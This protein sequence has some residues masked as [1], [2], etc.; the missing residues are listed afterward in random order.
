MPCFG[1]SLPL[2]QSGYR[3]YISS[4]LR[5][6]FRREES[7]FLDCYW[8]WQS[9]PWQEEPSEERP[10]TQPEEVPYP[11]TCRTMHHITHHTLQLATHLPNTCRNHNSCPVIIMFQPT[12]RHGR[13]L[14]TSFRSSKRTPVRSRIGLREVT[15]KAVRSL[16][17]SCRTTKTS[18][19]RG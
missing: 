3:T 10:D 14:L 2:G 17:C 6:V 13:R 15:G 19:I 5:C 4:I 9:E 18:A 8:A 7:W 12:Y 16:I 1:V 11:T